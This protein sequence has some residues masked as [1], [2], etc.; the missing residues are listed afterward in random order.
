MSLRIVMTTCNRNPSYVRSTLDS[1]YA[2]DPSIQGIKLLVHEP[3]ADFL[4]EKL[5]QFPRVVPTTLT[6]AEAADKA[7]L[8]RR[9]KVAHA[10]RL[11][12]E[13]CED[14]CILLQDDA[15]FQINWYRHFSKELDDFGPNRQWS[16]IALFHPLRHQLKPGILPWD[17][18]GYYGLVAMYFG[19]VARTKAIEALRAWEAR[20]MQS[21]G[22]GAD[23]CLKDMLEHDSDLRLFARF[24][25]LVDHTGLISSIASNPRERNAPTYEKPK[26]PPVTFVKSNAPKTVT[27]PAPAIGPPPAQSTKPR[28]NQNPPVRF[29]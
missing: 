22:M 6:E 18:R 10:T 12:L 5:A 2:A 13:L 14:E 20:G 1:M 16:M 28:K 26:R 8:A 11:A 29:K 27:L 25:A 21:P 24:P 4:A 15:T 3:N 19:S 9:V 23:V 7:K 17:P